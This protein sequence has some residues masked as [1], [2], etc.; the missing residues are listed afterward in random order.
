M[1]FTRGLRSLAG[2]QH[3]VRLKLLSP[4]PGRNA[5]S[6]PTEGS[7][8]Q[9]SRDTRWRMHL[10]STET[11]ALLS[12]CKAVCLLIHRD[13]TTGSSLWRFRRRWAPSLMT[14]C[15]TSHHVSPTSSLTPTEPWNCADMR[16]SSRPTTGTSPQKPS[17]QGF[18]MPSERGQP[19][20]LVA[21][22]RTMGLISA[23][24]AHC[25]WD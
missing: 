18:Q 24:V 4:Q 5:C 21:P 13:T 6:F 22:T 20:G 25:L 14:S 19:S 1:T 23:V 10:L 8:A 3:L 2:S 17:L 7:K 12:T 9:D 15:A 11:L 16:D